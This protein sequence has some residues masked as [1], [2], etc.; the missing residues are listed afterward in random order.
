M[1]L[2]L[3]Q[4]PICESNAG[5][6]CTATVAST[7]VTASQSHPSSEATTVTVS[8]VAV[9]PAVAG[10]FSLS[11]NVELVIAAGSTDSTGVVTVTAVDNDTDAPPKDVTVSGHGG[12]PDTDG[13]GDRRGSGLADADHRG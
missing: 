11:G 4:N 3:G 9:A 8:A 6:Q 13:A 10:D 5:G 12:E 1:T 2:T 7:A